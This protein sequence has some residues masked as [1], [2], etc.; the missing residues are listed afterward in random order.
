M[1]ERAWKRAERR[2]AKVLAAKHP[3]TMCPECGHE[4]P[5]YARV[6]ITGRQKGAS[7][8]IKHNWC[9]VEVKSYKH[10]PG[11]NFLVRAMEQAEEAAKYEELPI[12]V[13]HKTNSKHFS[14]LV[15]IRLPQFVEWFGSIL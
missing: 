2:I 6:P 12:V 8:D 15:V 1:G 5:S 14:D 4:Y 7:P 13:V 3:T 9:S 10:P 11:W